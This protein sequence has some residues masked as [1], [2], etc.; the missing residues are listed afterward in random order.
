L[1]AK[2]AEASPFLLISNLP[3]E[4]PKE[5]DKIDTA[6][7]DFRTIDAQDLIRVYN[8]VSV[9]KLSKEFIMNFEEFR[10]TRNALFHTVDGRLEFSD[11]IIITYILD[12]VNICAS[13]Q[14]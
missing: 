8:A 4:W 10:K 1:K 2:I 14:W 3:K 6:F 13:N 12:I 5:C 9:V 7:A 11:K